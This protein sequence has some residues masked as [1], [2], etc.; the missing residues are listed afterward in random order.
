[1]STADLQT[2]MVGLGGL[3]PSELRQAKRL[4]VHNAISQYRA[5]EESHSA[6][7]FVQI[8]FAIVPF[9]WPILYAQRRSM[10]ANKRL[11][12][13]R[14]TN[15]LMVWREDLQGEDFALPWDQADGHQGSAS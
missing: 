15:A 13:E 1:M 12:R 9:F 3:P 14:I 4:Y 2:F 8:L 11:L 10:A 6:L 5:L 7:G